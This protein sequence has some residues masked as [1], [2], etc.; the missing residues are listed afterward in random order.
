VLTSDAG[1]N[2]E[3]AVRF[4]DD[5][6]CRLLLERLCSPDSD[7]KTVRY[8]AAA[9]AALPPEVLVRYPPL[10]A[11]LHELASDNSAHP[12]AAAEAVRALA[13]VYSRGVNRPRLTRG[14]YQ[15]HPAPPT[16]ADGSTG[17]AHQA[18]ASE[19]E[20]DQM[21]SHL[22]A[23]EPDYDVVFI[24]GLA[25]NPFGTWCTAPLPAE[26]TH[27]SR[28]AVDVGAAADDVTLLESPSSSPTAALTSTAAASVSSAGGEETSA[29]ALTDDE[30]V[31][32]SLLE[33]WPRDWLP[34][35]LP[36]NPRILSI[37][38]EMYLSKW[39]GDTLPLVCF[40]G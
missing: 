30:R 8:G 17:S 40:W 9:L 21:L 4:G 2:S 23:P 27:A 24:H 13:A 36:G 35:D 37:G 10:L 34:H 14:V 3:V 31:D 16:A 5:E 26:S 22:L 20:R 15:L 28:V 18:T 12:Y 25:G 32:E 33:C 38:Y 6:E 19:D 29:T 11:R 39:Q 7:P 1:A